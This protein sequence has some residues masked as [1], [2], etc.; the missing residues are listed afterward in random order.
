MNPPDIAR[1]IAALKERI[2]TVV[3]GQREVVD[4]VLAGLL[5]EGHV[6]L[7]GAPGLGKTLLVK[8]LAECTSLAFSRIQF[9]PD[10][11]PSDVTGTTI[12]VT[13]A[14]ERRRGPAF[15]VQRGPVFTQLLLADEINRATP[16]TQSAL[17]EAMAER[18]V[19]LAGVRHELAPP[20]LVLA[21]ENPI[22]MEG[23]FPL[24]EAQ[25]DRFLLKLV[26]PS[27]TEDELCAVLE[28]TTGTATAPPTPLV[29]AER[30]RAWTAACRAVVAAPEVLRFCARLVHATDPAQPHAPALVK[31]ALRFGAGVRAAQSLV[32]AGKAMALQAGRGHVAFQ[33][34]LAVAKP[35]LRHRLVRSFEGEAEGIDADRVV[36][37]VCGAVD[38]RSADVRAKLAEGS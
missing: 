37:E 7:E 34:V 4:G 13:D 2:A 8:T 17:L 35:V 1:E 26:V 31:R 5:A 22:E 24:P 16:K 20:F 15:T 25:L 38:P 10:L 30:V 23:T 11:M 14:E 21:T 28:R 32:L 33:D 18:S 29:D 36:D 6:L 3:V 19:T 27:P 9:T 12:L